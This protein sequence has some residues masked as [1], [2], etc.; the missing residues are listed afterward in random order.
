[1]EL[2]WLCTCSM[3][4]DIEHRL[5]LMLHDIFSSSGCYSMRRLN[6]FVGTDSLEMI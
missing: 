3:S 4:Y 5:Y 6:E 1:M 2:L